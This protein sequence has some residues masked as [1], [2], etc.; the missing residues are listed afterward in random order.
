[1]GSF[2]RPSGVVELNAK[3][4]APKIQEDLASLMWEKE[5]LSERFEV[6][7]TTKDAIRSIN[8]CTCLA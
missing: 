4:S 7:D 5:I 8:E 3:Q 2:D 1:M 6:S